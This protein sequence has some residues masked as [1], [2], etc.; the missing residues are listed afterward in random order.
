MRAERDFSPHS[1]DLSEQFTIGGA[2]D[3]PGGFIWKSGHVPHTQGMS[4]WSKPFFIRTGPGQDNNM[5]VLLVDTQGTCDHETSTQLQGS[6]FGL[7]TTVSRSDF[8][9]QR[10]AERGGHI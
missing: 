7:S 1:D 9:K 4:V 6:L 8:W 5:A 2:N 10:G 3:G